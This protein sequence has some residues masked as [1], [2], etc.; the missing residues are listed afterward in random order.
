MYSSD[1]SCK[2]S[3]NEY[4][5]YCVLWGNKKKNLE[6]T[7]FTPY[8]FYLNQQ[9]HLFICNQPEEWVGGGDG[10][11]SDWRL[12]GDRGFDTSIK[13]NLGIFSTIILTLL[14][15]QEG[16]ITKTCLYN[17]DPIKP[18]FYIINLGFTRVYIIF[19]ISAQNHRLWVLVR[20]ASPWRF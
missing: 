2:G 18:H 4:P 9:E 7:P 5:Q 19:L 1:L 17:F 12:I 3:S 20:T 13:I 8:Y 10:G 14:L 15:I 16:H 6:H 11:Q